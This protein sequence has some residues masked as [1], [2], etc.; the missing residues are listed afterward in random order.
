MF[1]ALLILMLKEKQRKFD[2][3]IDA[4]I[5][6][7][8][9]FDPAR[10]DTIAMIELQIMAEINKIGIDAAQVYAPIISREQ[11]KM[12]DKTKAKAGFGENT[13]LD[14]ARINLLTIKNSALVRDY[15]KQVLA[16]GVAATLFDVFRAPATPPSLAE[17]KTIAIRK[18]TE[19]ANQSLNAHIGAIS[20]MTLN[21]ARNTQLI[22]SFVE[23]RITQY[24]IVAV[25]DSRTTRICQSLNGKTFATYDAVPRMNRI[26]NARDRAEIIN[27]NTFV[28]FD[29]TDY[30]ANGV[31][32][33]LS[34][35]PT[36]LAMN[37]LSFPPYHWGCRSTVRAVT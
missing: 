33:N 16:V 14:T 36:V 37:G 3:R 28:K 13:I 34:D 32:L 11:K 35:S 7:I 8:D 22:S 1:E 23:N 26:L 25:I 6:I 10:G 18:M 29:G 21:W 15:F 30:F 19:Y 27:A 5:R 20:P 12:A 9:T 17:M 24:Q 2:A 4:A 31:K